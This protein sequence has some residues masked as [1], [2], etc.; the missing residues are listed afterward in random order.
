MQCFK[1]EL[2]EKSGLDEDQMKVLECGIRWA[3][4]ARRKGRD[5]QQEQRRQAKQG[6]K[7]EQEQSKQGK[8]VRFGEEQQ[9]GKTGAEN[10]GEPEVM[11]RTIE[12]RTGRGSTGLVRGGDERCRADETSKG[13]GK[14]NGGKGEHE[15]KGGGFGHSGKQQEMREREEERVRMAPNMGAGG[16]HPQATSD[17]GEEQAA[18]GEQQRNEEKEEILKLLKGWQEKETSPIMRWAWADE[19]TE[20]ESNQENGEEKKETRG[21]SWADCED[22]EGEKNKE[23]QETAGERQ[24]EAERKQKQEQEQ[25]QEGDREREAKSKKEQEEGARQEELT[26]EEPPGL[27]EREESKHKAH[28]EERS[29]QEAREDEESRAQ[30]AREE[31]RRVQE[32]HE[33]ERRAQEAREEQKRAQEAREEE[34]RAQEAREEE[35]RAQEAREERKAQ[36]EREEE[37]EVEAQEGHEEVKEVT[38]Q[39]KCVEAKKENSTHEENDVSNRHMTWW[40]NAWWVRMD[41]GPHLRTARGR[42][43]AWRAATRAAREARETEQVAGGEREEWEHGTTKR[44]ATHHVLHVVFHFPTATA[45][46][47]AAAVAASW[48]GSDSRGDAASVT[49]TTGSP[50]AERAGQQDSKLLFRHQKD[51]VLVQLCEAAIL[52]RRSLHRYKNLL[53]LDGTPLTMGLKIAGDVM[54]KLI[55]HNDYLFHEEG[56]QMFTTYADNQPGVLIQIFGWERGMIEDNNLLGKFHL[57]GIMPAPRVLPQVEVTFDINVIDSSCC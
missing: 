42:R 40:R 1:A 39:E 49:S 37:R 26:N 7:T 14:G 57:A 36:E 55:E 5:K 30:E 16:S 18:E 27:E 32:A 24:Q 43:R 33:E 29:T 44:K 21:M 50:P 35:R 19:S 20:E 4:E 56:M 53:L 3:V 10:T 23:E 6:E 47:Y 9:L 51:F 48:N 15:G 28:E 25:E 54:T 12:V 34:R 41:N 52:W 46:T 22:D 2:H 8:Q 38:T 31:E 45:A 13:K 17:P 11:G